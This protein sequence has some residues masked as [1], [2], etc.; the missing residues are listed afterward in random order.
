MG[1][2]LRAYVEEQLYNDLLIYYPES[3][4]VNF[5][6]SHSVMEGT[7]ANYLGGSLENYSAIFLN[8]KDGNFI[9][10]G[11][12]E[13]IMKDNILITYWDSLEF[14][15]DLLALNKCKNK[16]F[17]DPPHIV[18]IINEMNNND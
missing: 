8:D 18:K 4:G 12:M 15:K 13:F 17:G 14:S 16:N 1:P 10:E 6:W 11:W 3:S 9:A 2:K 7:T 5:D